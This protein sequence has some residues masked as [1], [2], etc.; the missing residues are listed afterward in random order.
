MQGEAKNSTG[1]KVNA[2]E[3]QRGKKRSTSTDPCKSQKHSGRKPIGERWGGRPED[4]WGV[5]I[6]MRGVFVLRSVAVTWR[7][8]VPDLL[9]PRLMHQYLP[10][11]ALCYMLLAACAISKFLQVRMTCFVCTIGHLLCRN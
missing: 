3:L 10:R 2:Q 11:T 1:Q 5:Q 9:L 8:R 6:K 7:L 4:A